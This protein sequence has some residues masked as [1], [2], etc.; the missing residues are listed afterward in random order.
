MHMVITNKN[1]VLY[2]NRNR[3][4]K[5]VVKLQCDRET[6]NSY[7]PY[8]VSASGDRLWDM[9]FVMFLWNHGT[10]KCTITKN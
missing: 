4:E 10:I 7:D 9:S 2:G 6:D 1:I 5:L 8:A 3:E